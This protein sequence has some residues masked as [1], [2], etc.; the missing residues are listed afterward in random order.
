MNRTCPADIFW[1]VIDLIY[2]RPFPVRTLSLVILVFTHGCWKDTVDSSFARGACLL[3]GHLQ[4][5]VRIELR[6]LARLC[7]QRTGACLILYA[8]Q[9]QALLDD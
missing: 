1:A 2:G 4:C 9:A 7:D 8:P 6:A 3:D 5:R